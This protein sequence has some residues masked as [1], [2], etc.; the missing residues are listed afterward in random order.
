MHA[1]SGERS[2]AS[3]DQSCSARSS[4]SPRRRSQRRIRFSTRAAEA[5]P[6]PPFEPYLYTR[7]PAVNLVTGI[8]LAQ[9][10]VAACPYFTPPSVKKAVKQLANVPANAQQAWADRQWATG[11]APDAHCLALGQEPTAAPGATSAC[12]SWPVPNLSGTLFPATAAG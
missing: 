4:R 6:V 9:A 8:V 1:S 10:L 5:T 3:F 11:V 2:G 7:A 12:A